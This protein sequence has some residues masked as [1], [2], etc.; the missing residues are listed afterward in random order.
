VKH[1]PLLSHIPVI[2]VT[3]LESASDKVA[4]VE[5]GADDYITKPF[6][7]EELRAAIK[8]KLQVKRRE[9]ALLRKT[10]ELEAINAVSAAANS[11]LDPGRVT[12]DSFD[13]LVQNVDLAAAAL[14]RY[15]EAHKDLRCV[16]QWGVTRPQTLPEEGLAAQIFCAETPV[17][18][19]DLTDDPDLTPHSLGRSDLGAFIGVALRAGEQSLGMLEVYHSQPYGLE[20]QDLAFYAQI[21]T[22]IGSALQNA[23]IFQQAQTLLLK[24]SSLGPSE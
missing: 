8:A 3:A 1:D 24:S 19:V 23:E 12:R 21:G 5:F 18:K 15:N 14:F 4:A 11:S 16:I 6:L 2:M 13:T 17:L 10:R 7:P 22:R 9:E 20:E